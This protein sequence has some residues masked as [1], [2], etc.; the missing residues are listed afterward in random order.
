MACE[1]ELTIGPFVMGGNS[2]T[3]SNDI[4][5]ST[6]IDIEASIQSLYPGQDCAEI[7]S[8][9]QQVYEGGGIPV[10]PPGNMRA[11]VTDGFVLNRNDITWQLFD[12]TSPGSGNGYITGV[13][14]GNSIP[15]TEFTF[16]WDAGGITNI[17]WM[18]VPASFTFSATQWTELQFSGYFGGIVRPESTYPTYANPGAILNIPDL[19]AWVGCL[20]P[21]C[22]I[23]PPATDLPNV[24]GSVKCANFSKIFNPLGIPLRSR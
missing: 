1:N 5:F 3:E 14:N 18:T 13:F 11:A 23:A 6:L 17:D 8:L 10:P 2:P 4:T 22:A 24:E 15:L 20:I 16:T 9:V 7:L 12:Y 19:Q 21:A